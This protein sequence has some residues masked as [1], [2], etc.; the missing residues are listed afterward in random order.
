MCEIV[1]NMFRN[2]VVESIRTLRKDNLEKGIFDGLCSEGMFSTD[3]VSYVLTAK[4][5]MSQPE[6]RRAIHQNFP[7]ITGA[8]E[9]SELLEVDSSA[10]KFLADVVRYVS[11][12][13]TTTKVPIGSERFSGG[14]I[15]EKSPK[16]KVQI[17]INI[18]KDGD[19][20]P[21]TWKP[22]R[23]PTPLP[24]K[25]PKNSRTKICKFILSKEKGIQGKCFRKRCNFAHS[26][27]S[28]RDI[29]CNYG[30]LCTMKSSCRFRHP[31]ESRE[32]FLERVYPELPA[33]DAES[34]CSEPHTPLDQPIVR[35]V[36]VAPRKCKSYK[37]VWTS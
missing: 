9:D 2:T 35:E 19:D 30:N 22:P 15:S 29:M 27:E 14:K 17:S 10:I 3:D 24:P 20:I 36:P 32:Q 18:E 37:I 34:R 6:V 5:L 13:F 21:D 26:K 7:E 11:V 25:S 33:T 28:L 31:N 12:R 16:K 1:N 8:F 4:K 23:D